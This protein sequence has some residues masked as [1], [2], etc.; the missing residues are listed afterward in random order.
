MNASVD[1]L[2]GRKFASLY[3]SLEYKGK[4]TWDLDTIYMPREQEKEKE[5]RKIN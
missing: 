5:K 3:D 2:D 4:S 1:W